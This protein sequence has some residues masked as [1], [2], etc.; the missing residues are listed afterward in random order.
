MLAESLR[1]VLCQH[2]IPRKDQPGRTI[3][4]EVMLNND[5]LSNLIRKGKCFQIPSVIATSR[6]VGMQSMDSE[7]MRLYREGK[8]A[9]EEAYIRAIDKK[10]F[11]AAFGW[12]AENTKTTV[13]NPG[14]ATIASVVPAGA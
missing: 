9:A 13:T 10:V 2:L 12:T 4:V 6:D 8:V 1:A 7:L 5:A 14:R 3:A 11:E